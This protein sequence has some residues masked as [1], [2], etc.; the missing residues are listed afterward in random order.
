MVTRAKE[1]P[2]AADHQTGKPTAAEIVLGD[3]LKSFFRLED[4]RCPVLVDDEEVV[5]GEDWRG[6]E[7][8]FQTVLPDLLTVCGVKT[9]RDA[10][11]VD[12][13]QMTFMPTVARGRTIPLS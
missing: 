5:P 4:E 12:D 1:K 11:V 7:V 2:F 13:V 6:A 3:E 9:S 10:V 8:S